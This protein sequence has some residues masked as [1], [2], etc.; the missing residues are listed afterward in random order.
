LLLNREA[1]E[2]GAVST[3]SSD[4]FL[5]RGE[6]AQSRDWRRPTPN[7]V[8][9]QIVPA[10]L[11]VLAESE[12]PELRIGCLLAL[13]RLGDLYDARTAESVHAALLAELS[14]GQ[15]EVR[16]VAALSLGLME[17][18]SGLDL[19]V[20]VLGD[21]PAARELTGQEI[22]PRTR[23]FASLGLALGT[24]DLSDAARLRYGRALE[25]QLASLM[26]A[27]N[28][29]AAA[30]AVI[31]IGLCPQPFAPVSPEAQL[32]GPGLA[33]QIENLQG[34]IYDRHLR[35]EVGAHIPQALARLAQAL[36]DHPSAQ[37]QREQVVSRL[38]EIIRRQGRARQLPDALRDGA[39]LAMGELAAMLDDPQ[40]IEAVQA[41]ER[42]IDSGNS[43]G[44]AFALLSLGRL[45]A[46]ADPDLRRQIE[47][48]L[49]DELT[50]A[51][52]RRGAWASLGLGLGVK[53]SEH[54]GVSGPLR[55]KW[56]QSL[57]RAKSPDFV[58]A[59]GIGMGLAGLSSEESRL[60]QKFDELSEEATRGYLAEALGLAGA[61]KAHHHLGESLSDA[62]N[63]PVLLGRLAVALGLMG[64]R[65]VQAR[66]LGALDE[67]R[68]VPAQGYLTAAIGLVG[69]QAALPPL[70]E[71][72]GDTSNNVRL[73]AFAAAA[74]G[75]LADP[76]PQPWNAELARGLNY[77]HA[78]PA[79]FDGSGWGLLELL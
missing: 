24:R 54:R 59:L 45:G 61:R 13:G 35:P 72:L 20:E 28:S 5:G 55:T 71:I 4:Y 57:E 34:L 2:R 33:Q 1:L 23:A 29:E 10:L 3:G 19:L 14:D 46:A 79:L 75:R 47:A 78:P 65:S 50:H 69:D 38:L 18:P 67:T 63:Q 49:L 8:T 62:L 25:Q 43:M 58:S 42:S 22:L 52:R 39:L 9:E 70:L 56:V 68:S 12:S 41:L 26:R 16:A 31:A 51:P 74:L 6:R 40:R 17:D 73:R 77:R 15:S 60:L 53:E 64:D 36:P 37:R 44:P 11:T 48:R 21:T 76:D 30:S 27:G 66:L 32:I 7:D